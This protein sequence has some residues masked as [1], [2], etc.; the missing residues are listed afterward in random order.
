MLRQLDPLLNHLDSANPGG[1]VGVYLYGSS[2]SSGLRPDSDVDVLML[3]R[4]SLDR[5]ER[6]ALVALLLG[7]SG[8]KGHTSESAE[9]PRPIE[10]TSV[11]ID[12]GGRQVPSVHDLQFGE[13]L[14]P[15][16]ENGA[17]LLAEDDPDVPILLATAQTTH[18]VLRGRALEDVLDP[19]PARAVHDAMLAT[20]PDIL[21]EIEGDERNTLLAL[22]RMLI[23]A[24]TGRIVSKDEA[25]AQ[26]VPELSE[27]DR[28]LL[29]RARTGYLGTTADDWSGASAAV[30]ALAH[31]LA[32]RVQTT[33]DG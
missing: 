2:V 6:A 18:R 21:E 30:T 14:R 23:T 32:R 31:T 16:I 29:E 7:I 19:V 27:A 28:E 4:R 13:W 26:V 5:E 12:D 20:I 8:G 3:T 11:V 15:D 33:I 24:R 9:A 10:L 25:A 17:E 22:A 1:V